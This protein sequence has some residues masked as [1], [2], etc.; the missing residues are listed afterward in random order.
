MWLLGVSDKNWFWDSESSESSP[1]QHRHHQPGW[2]VCRGHS[3]PRDQL[4]RQVRINLWHGD[5]Q[6]SAPLP[7][8]VVSRK[9]FQPK[10]FLSRSWIRLWWLWNHQVCD[11]HWNTHL[12]CEQ[13][14]KGAFIIIDSRLQNVTTP[15][16]IHFSYPN[17]CPKKCLFVNKKI[18]NLEN[19]N[20]IDNA[21]GVRY[22][23]MLITQI[24]CSAAILHTAEP[25][26]RQYLTGVTG[27]VQSFNFANT[28]FPQFLDGTN[29]G[30]YSICIRNWSW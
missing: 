24:P 12:H 20:L 22:W 26:C 1:L 15:L 5:Q 7:G 2:Q 19:W 11:Q 28:N 14:R 3:Q 23:S 13:V 30:T 17:M 8:S 18:W 21:S 27:T 6:L 16:P 9:I 29:S 4:R 25:G 10:I